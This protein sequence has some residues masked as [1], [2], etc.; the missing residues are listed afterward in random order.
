M[1]SQIALTLIAGLLA[2]SVSAMPKFYGRVDVSVDYLPRDNAVKKDDNHVQLNL[3]NT[4]I[5][6][7]G[8]EKLSERLKLIYQTEWTAV[9]KRNGPEVLTPRNQFIGLKDEKLGT[10]KFGKHD[11]PLKQLG[12]LVDSYNHAVENNAD[13]QGIMGGENR[14]DLSIYYESAAFKVADGQVNFAVSLPKGKSQAIERSK[15]GS[16]V[17]GKDFGSAYSTSF[18]FKNDVLTAGLGYD[19]AIPSNFMRKGFLT[20]VDTETSTSGA[21]AA[22]NTIRAVARVNV[23]QNLSLR[24]LYQNAEVKD[25]QGNSANATNIDDADSWVLGMQYTLPEAK[26]WTLKAQYTATKTSMKYGLDDR[27]IWQVMGGADYAVSKNLKAYGYAGYLTLEQGLKEDHQ[28]LVGTGL[29]Y[30]F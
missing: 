21:F 14:V 23:D 15:G 13:I 25:K 26:Q 24:A 27:E 7:K 29:E 18:T 3:N 1:K 11:T 30:K 6:I 22:A 5:G 4:F 28:L 16:T 19:Y 20:A 2:G 10:L 17:A 12:L 8:E 9:L